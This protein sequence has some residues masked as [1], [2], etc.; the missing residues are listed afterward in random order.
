M[1]RD[2]AFVGCIDILAAR[3]PARALQDITA[4]E[5][6]L[7]FAATMAEIHD[8]NVAAKLANMGTDVRGLIE[9]RVEGLLDAGAVLEGGTL[10]E[11]VDPL[12]RDTGNPLRDAVRSLLNADQLS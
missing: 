8:A 9:A 5:P 3:L 6:A 11:R 12:L 4:G 10:F 2:P 7:M 1:N